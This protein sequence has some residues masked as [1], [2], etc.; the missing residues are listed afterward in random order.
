[1]KKHVA[2]IAMGLIKSEDKFVVLSDILG[3]EDHLGDMD[4][5]VA[6]T[7]DGVTSIQMDIKVKGLTKEILQ[8][9]LEQARIGRNY[10]LDLMYQAIPE[11]RKELS[12]YAPTVTTLRVLPEKI[13]VIIGPAGKNIKKIIEET[14][15][16]IDLDPTGLVKIY[17][18][19]KVA[20]EKAIDMINQL[21]MDIELREVYLG[22]VTRVEDYG[23]FVELMPGKLSLLHVSQI[24]SERLKSAKDVIKVGD[25]LKVKVSEI[26]DQ[27]RIKVSLKDVP[28]NVEAKNKFLFK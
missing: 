26:D 23:A 3:D 25:V 2:G 20:A 22:K 5:K 27:G 13:S 21:I 11:P 18:T 9:A 7:R 24:S 12:P 17:A 28:E 6:G 4:F 10:I 16:K 14:G 1:M 8:K 15:V 19:S